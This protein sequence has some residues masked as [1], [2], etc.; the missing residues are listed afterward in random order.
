MIWGWILTVGGMIILIWQR[1][2]QPFRTRNAYFNVVELIAQMIL[3]R[4][5]MGQTVNDPCFITLLF[6]LVCFSSDKANLLTQ[7]STNIDTNIQLYIFKHK[8]RSEKLLAKTIAT[9]PSL[10]ETS[11]DIT[12]PPPFMDS[13]LGA[14]L[15]ACSYLLEGTLAMLIFSDIPI[16]SFEGCKLLYGYP[17]TPEIGFGIIIIIFT[18]MITYILQNPETG[19]VFYLD[20]EVWLSIGNTLFML[21]F[22]FASHYAKM[23][24]MGAGNQFVVDFLETYVIQTAYSTIFTYNVVVRFV[25]PTL[26]HELVYR[27]N[28]IV[29]ETVR[30]QF[31]LV[32]KQPFA[33]KKLIEYAGTELETDSVLLYQVVR[34]IIDLRESTHD[35]F[36]QCERLAKLIVD[37][38]IRGRRTTLH[39]YGLRYIVKDI[40]TPTE[41]IEKEFTV[42]VEL[43]KNIQEKIILPMFAR[44]VRQGN[45]SR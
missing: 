6:S 17:N 2:N 4:C 42:L 40:K 28:S 32:Q 34:S 11:L 15:V 9:L 18:L 5:V 19:R 8:I 26:Y 36:A 24:L 13:L 25:V 27:K 21:L 33:M 29:D 7:V 22:L 23:F 38:Y 12:A 39:V 45:S 44:M 20:V 16:T 30:E 3:T 37:N 1:N 10:K 35:A 43:N 41:L 31:A 14:I